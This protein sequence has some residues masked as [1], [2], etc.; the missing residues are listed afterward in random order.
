V[1]IEYYLVATDSPS[2]HEAY[3]LGSGRWAFSCFG[4]YAIH[5]REQFIADRATFA[6][7]MQWAWNHNA[8]AIQ[9]EGDD[10]WFVSVVG[11]EVWD[12][13]AKHS[14]RVTMLDDCGDMSPV[15][16][17]GS[18]YEDDRQLLARGE[19]PYPYMMTRDDEVETDDEG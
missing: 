7:H 13:C 5:D 4:R 17:V 9:D 8:N 3:C 11:P 2:P 1:T 19:H 14:W 15:R 6:R 12:F 18:R 16:V 10:G